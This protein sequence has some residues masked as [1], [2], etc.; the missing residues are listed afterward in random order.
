MVN[1]GLGGCEV[2]RMWVRRMS[3]DGQR[4]RCGGAKIAIDSRLSVSG[5]QNS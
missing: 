1:G 2:R 3:G 5:L 4:V